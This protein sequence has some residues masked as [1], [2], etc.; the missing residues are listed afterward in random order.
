VDTPAGVKVFRLP[1][2]LSPMAVVR[3]RSTGVR[4]RSAE[5]GRSASP[6]DPGRPLDVGRPLEPGR[7]DRWKG[8]VGGFRA[9]IAGSDRFCLRS[10]ALVVVG[11]FRREVVDVLVPI[12][13]LRGVDGPKDDVDEGVVGVG[14]LVTED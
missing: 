8:F 6:L 9:R 1:Y 7:V 11:S 2:G 14:M 3:W 12:S 10:C 5:G 4:G 13:L